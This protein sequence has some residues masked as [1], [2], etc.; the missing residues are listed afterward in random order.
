MV[1]HSYENN[2]TALLLVDPYNDFL[3]VGGKLWPSVES[4][5]NEVGLLDNLRTITA[6][7]R[8]AGIQIVIVPHRRWEPGDYEGWH[9]PN[10]Y[11][12]ASGEKQMFAKGCWGGEWHSDF[13]PQQGDII[14]KE[15]WGVSGFA[16]TDLDF[17]LKQR[18]IIQVI[19]IGL[20]SNTCIKPP[21]VLRRSSAIAS[22]WSR[23]QPLR[24]ARTGF[25][26]R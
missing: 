10:P 3:A 9:H 13:V 16:N 7:I 5:A 2:R 25:S 22:R 14:V 12:V 1:K 15:H 4:V 8:A 21:A 17:H 20:L 24:S 23:R 18:G 6:A 11:Q 19:V 26:L